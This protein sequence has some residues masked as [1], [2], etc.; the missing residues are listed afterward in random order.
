M[1]H[2]RKLATKDLIDYHNAV[3][4]TPD[5]I[6]AIQYA[7]SVSQYNFLI[8]HEIGVKVLIWAGNSYRAPYYFG[9][10]HKVY[11][12][13][14][15]K[16]TIYYYSVER[17]DGSIESCINWGFVSAPGADVASIIQDDINAA[18]ERLNIERKFIKQLE[19]AKKNVS[20][21]NPTWIGHC[22]PKARQSKQ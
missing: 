7:A 13:I 1:L 14:Y 21:G 4:M 5:D 17:P 22:P 12:L 9:T 6:A 3:E 11:K 10:V 2:L 20:S 16:N 18:K 19:S 8:P 15:N